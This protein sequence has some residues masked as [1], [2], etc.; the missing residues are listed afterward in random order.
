MVYIGIDHHKQYSHLTI[1]DED[2]STLKT[3]RIL[4][5]REDVISFLV[6]IKEGIKAVLEAGRATYTMV[7]LLE[8]LGVEVTIAH[9]FQVKAIAQAKIKTDKRDSYIL[10]HL[11]RTDLIPTVYRREAENRAQQR[12][13]RHRMA[14]VRMQTQIKNRIRSLLAHQCEKIRELVASQN[15]LFKSRGLLQLREIGLP[16]RDGDMLKS[17]IQTFD[18]IQRRIQQSNVLVEE[19]F[20]RNEDARLI[21]SIPGFGKFFSVL[22]ATEIANIERFSSPAK[23]H[24]YAGVIPST[25]A[26]GEKHYHGG[27]IRQGD[28]WLRWALVEAVW[29]AIKSDF[30]LRV[31]YQRIAKGKGANSVK[32]AT[33]RRLLTIIFRVLKEKRSYVSY[34]R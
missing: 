21:I 7:D 11:L 22:V 30:D 34:K 25:H 15:Q 32:V 10:A 27:L 17:L 19:I 20:D 5:R 31:Y 33:A 8:E 26:S 24:S 29:P 1:L 16:G 3:G 13:L 12:I 23:L 18:H 2:G 6:G 28:K 4:N 9:P 14:Y